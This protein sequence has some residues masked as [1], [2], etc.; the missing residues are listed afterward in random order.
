M[1]LQWLRRLGA[2]AT[3]VTVLYVGFA[4]FDYEPRPVPLALLATVCTAAAWLVLDVLGGVG[5]SWEV[6]PL[7]HAVP[8]G[9]DARLAANVRILEGHITST[10]P[11]GA[12]H[13]RLGELAGALLLQRHGLSRD[14]PRAAAV[15]GPELRSVLQGQPERLRPEEIERLVRSLE[16]L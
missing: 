7:V 14:D 16:E 5:P 10:T 2:L 9:Q 13:H 15:L 12:L 8:P 6:P 1:R 11:D 3:L 4:V